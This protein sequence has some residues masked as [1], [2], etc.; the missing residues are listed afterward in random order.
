MVKGVISG[1]KKQVLRIRNIYS[2]SVFFHPGS[3]IKKAPDPG[4]STKNLS[5][6]NSSSWS[7]DPDPGSRVRIL[8]HSGSRCLKKQRKRQLSGYPTLAYLQKKNMAKKSV[9]VPHHTHEL[10]VLPRKNDENSADNRLAVFERIYIGSV[11]ISPE[12]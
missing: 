1:L 4:P 9:P 2:G 11:L 5:I 12:R 3:M 10:W 8:S 7:Y 6:F